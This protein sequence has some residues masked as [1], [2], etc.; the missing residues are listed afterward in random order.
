M[1]FFENGVKGMTFYQSTH[2]RAEESLNF[3]VL[4]FCG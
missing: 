3:N 2:V 1:D 4:F